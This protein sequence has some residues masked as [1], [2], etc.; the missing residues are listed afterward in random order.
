M[1]AVD[2]NGS[3]G[4][5]VTPNGEL[6]RVANEQRYGIKVSY[7]GAKQTFSFSS[8]STGDTSQ[9]DVNF[10]VPTFN[11]T[12][13]VPTG[14]TDADGNPTLQA[15]LSSASFMGFEVT[16]TTDS[17]YS[18]LPSE[19]AVRGVVSLPAVSQG[20]SIAVN[21]NNNFSVDASNNTFV[22]SVDDVRA[23]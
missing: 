16:G 3:Y 23:P 22:V 19:E 8:G 20:S 11:A 14:A 7:D 13:G 10:S 21:V 4:Q 1:V 9:V 18:E 12:S 17:L 2:S 6:Q 15:N 5:T